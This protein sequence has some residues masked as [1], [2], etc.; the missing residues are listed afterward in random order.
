M[1]AIDL[2]RGLLVSSPEWNDGQPVRVERV[3]HPVAGL[4]AV[5]YQDA[6]CHAPARAVVV[7]AGME[8]TLIS[9]GCIGGGQ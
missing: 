2:H 6:L 5:R 8:L 1:V 3:A 4:V 7:E 9:G